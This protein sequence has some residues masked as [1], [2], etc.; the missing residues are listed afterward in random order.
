M[1]DRVK[2]IRNDEDN[3]KKSSKMKEIKIKLG[4]GVFIIMTVAES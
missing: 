1:Y 2:K 4:G 3:P